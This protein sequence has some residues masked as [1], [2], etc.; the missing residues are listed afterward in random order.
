MLPVLATYKTELVCVWHNQSGIVFIFLTGTGM[1]IK[2]LGCSGGID[3]NTRTTSFLLNNDALI[4]AG[5]GVCDLSLQMQMGIRHVFLTHSHFDH[6]AGL[7]FL[8]DS[9][10][11]HC[12]KENLPPIKIYALAS[13]LDDLHQC[14]FNNRIWPDFT[15]LPSS[16]APTLECIP[17]A[18]G[19]KITLPDDCVIEAIPAVH[20]VPTVGYAVHQHGQSWVFTGDTGCNPLLWQYINQLPERGLFLRWLVAEATFASEK[21]SFAELTGHYT[22]HSLAQDMQ[23]LHTG[24]FDLYLTHLK[25]CNRSAILKDMAELQTVAYEKNC[26]L[27]LLTRGHVFDIKQ[28]HAYKSDKA[29][30]AKCFQRVLSAQ[31]SVDTPF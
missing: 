30:V 16:Q 31:S 23:L 4:D 18:V 11:R 22:P 13:V 5:T 17:I 15:Q 14:I 20:N 25:P 24:N 12:H 29:H 1:Q 10:S 2:V 8:A 26:N 9:V 28:P 19:D 7:P 3:T 21:Q 27:H 6:L